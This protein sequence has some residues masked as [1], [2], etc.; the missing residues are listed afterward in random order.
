MPAFHQA[1]FA[2]PGA[3]RVVLNLGGIANISVLPGQADGGG[4]RGIWLRY[5]PANTLLDELV[6]PPPAPRWQL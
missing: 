4:C 3:L 5:R 6:S 2:R 1:L